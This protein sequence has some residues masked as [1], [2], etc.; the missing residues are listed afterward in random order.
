MADS[1]GERSVFRLEPEGPEVPPDAPHRLA[2]N[3][4]VLVAAIV[5]GRARTWL[6]KAD[7]QLTLMMW[8]R[9]F[10]ARFDP[11][12][13]LDEAGQVVAKGGEHVTVVGG[14]LPSGA[15]GHERVFGA[16]K[17]SRAQAEGLGN[18]HP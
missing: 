3:G 16:W 9:V 5:D 7:G 4:G 15:L 13:L 14:F 8:P 17:V 6:A 11:L 12:E 10:R 1:S 2:G 18:R